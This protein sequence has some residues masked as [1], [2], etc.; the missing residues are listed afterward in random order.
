MKQSNRLYTAF[1]LNLCFSVFELIGGILTGSVAIISDAIHDLGDAA[2]IGVSCLLERKSK[3]PPD[4][5]HSFGYGRFSVMGALLTTAILI[6]GSAA[7]ITNAISRLIHPTVIHYDGMIL[8]AAVGIV[9]NFLAAW[10]TRG[11]DSIHQKAI[12][13]HMLEDVLGWAVVLIGALI[14]RFTGLAVLDPL[15][16]I[17]VAIF[18]LIHAIG[19]LKDVLDI[20]LEKTPRSICPEELRRHLC[21]LPGVS[22]IHH[23]H[24]W[25]LDGVH[26]FATMHVV[27]QTDS[28]QLK[29]AVRHA[30]LDF[31]IVHATLE[32]ENV[33]CGIDHC[34]VLAD[35]AAH[36]HHHHH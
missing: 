30:L 22:D 19:N 18:I 24:I 25:T 1:F 5:S 17:G 35:K 10:V 34:P 8:F 15:M 7:V 14:M 21:T 28:P 16:S 27:C 3:L 36:H 32:T 6:F 31:N 4:E 29:E 12:N 11:G 33:P 20:L 13:L 9:V 2:G 26:N 23:I